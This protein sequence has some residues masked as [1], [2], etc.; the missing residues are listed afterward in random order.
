MEL[1]QM[2]ILEDRQDDVEWLWDKILWAVAMIQLSMPVLPESL[3]TDEGVNVDDAMKK[4][5]D[6]DIFSVQLPSVSR[7]DRQ[8][9]IENLKGE[10]ELG[11]V[12]VQT[13]CEELG[14]NY[15][16]E[17]QKIE[18]HNDTYGPVVPPEK[19][20]EEEIKVEHDEI[21]GEARVK[22][23][24]IIDKAMSEASNESRKIIAQ[25]RDHARLT[26]ESAKDE[27]KMEAER[28]KQEL[29]KEVADM[30]VSL[31]GKV[32]DREI[33]SSD[34]KDLIDKGLDV[35]GS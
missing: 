24:E 34:H 7:R 29:R 22:A 16:K 9:L 8:R 5:N 20:S 17:M 31:A 32:L 13:K 33:K 4:L 18:E 14:R 23:S 10:D 1:P 11:T 21:I 30:T 3:N 25:A 19:T 35:L 26:V 12:S 15:E 28:I 2:K 27:I 6:D